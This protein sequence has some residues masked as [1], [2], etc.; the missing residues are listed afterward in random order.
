MSTEDL[1]CTKCGTLHSPF[2]ACPKFDQHYLNVGWICPKCGAG[3]SPNNFRCN[4]TPAPP[5]QITC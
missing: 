3:N 1:T 2:M 4:C 5:I